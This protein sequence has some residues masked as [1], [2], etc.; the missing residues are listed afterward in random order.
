PAR[1]P[2]LGDRAVVTR[3]LMTLPPFTAVH[4][5]LALKPPFRF[6][7]MT[8]RVFPLRARLTALQN[9]V[10]QYLNVIP[11]EVG[12]F[13]AFLPYVH[14]MVLDYGKIA[15]A[16]ANAGWLSQVEI[17]FGV[18]VEWYRSRNGRW[19]FE[20]WA[21]VAPF[22]FVDS[23]VS[24]TLGR[25]VIG[26][27]KLLASVSTNDREWLHNPRGPLS[28][29]TVSTM[30]Y[31]RLYAG[32]WQQMEPF[33]EIGRRP[34]TPVFEVPLDMRNPLMPWTLMGDF[35]RM[36]DGLMRDAAALAGAA[37][38]RAFDPRLAARRA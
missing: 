10:D 20:G 6:E 19:D 7:G 26:W 37:A 15:L 17:L 14:L 34:A 12:R 23:D 32:A 18:P 11:K 21:W 8:T 30:V 28:L 33:L 31:P 1:A 25:T 38:T 4:Q 9:F 36:W 16:I 13:R 3:R 27:P 35:A 29:A 24:L 5:S 2:V 22:I